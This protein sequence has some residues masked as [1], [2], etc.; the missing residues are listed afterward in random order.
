MSEGEARILAKLADLD[1][2][3]TIIAQSLTKAILTIGTIDAR[4]RKVE[5]QI[6]GAIN[7]N[8]AVDA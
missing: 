7:G 3:V 4:L 1:E 8:G 2:K 6:E 5:R